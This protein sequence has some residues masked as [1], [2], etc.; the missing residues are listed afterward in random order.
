MTSGTIRIFNPSSFFFANRQLPGK[1][2][3]EEGM[4]LIPDQL[5]ISSE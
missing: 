2:T 3:I 5:D 1:A 4:E